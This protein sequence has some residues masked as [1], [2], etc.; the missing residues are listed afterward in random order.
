[1]KIKRSR[2][3]HALALSLATLPL[4]VWAANDFIIDDIRVEGLQ[5]ISIGTIF[6]YLP[7]KRG[8]QF[9]DKISIEAIQ[10]LYRT[11]FFKDVVL[12]REGDTLVVFVAERPAISS[13]TF[14]GNKSI[15]TDKLLENLKRIGFAEGRVFDRSMLDKVE[16]ELKR[17]Y[18]SMGKYGVQLK[19]TITPEER[20]RSA[21]HIAM[22]EGD[23]ATIYR[24]NIV[25]NKSFSTG[26]LLSQFQLGL[27]PAILPFSDRDKYSKQKLAGDLE[28]LRSWYL[29]RGYIN[30]KI[31]STQVS[32]TPDYEHIY[33]TINIVE[34]DRYTVR[35]VKVAGESLVPNEIL[36]ELINIQP[37]D[38]FSRKHIAESTT[39]ISDR[40]GNEG[41]AFAN[42]NAIPELDEENK[43]VSLT[44]FVDPG[45]RVYVRRVNVF[46]NTKTKD[47]VVRREIRQMEGGWISTERIK[48]SRM[49]LER[50]SYLESVNVETPAV[51]GEAEQVDVNYT[52]QE[53]DTFGSLSFG[54]GYGDADG[55]VFN[56]SVSQDNFL[57]TGQRFSVD[58]DTSKVSS[59]YSLNLVDPYY[60]MN[61][62]SR[63]LNFFYRSMDSGEASI[64]E[65]WTDS[66][67]AGVTFGI[68]LA[69][70]T[71]AY[72]GGSYDHTYLKNVP[73][74]TQLIQDFVT[75]N[76]D[77]SN[78]YKLELS[79]VHDTRNRY[80]FPS[81]G[82][83]I[84]LGAEI[85][86]PIGD[87]QFYKLNYRHKMYIP[88][89]ESVILS[90]GGELAYGHSY[91]KTKGVLPPFERYY[92]GGT[93]SVR[94]YKSSSLGSPVT[95]DVNGDP[96]GGNSK[97]VG[98]LE[99][100]LPGPF[101]ENSDS[102][103]L[104]IFL[105]GGNVYD[106]SKEKFNLGEL[107][108]STGAT[109]YWM[110]PVGALTFTIANA[111]N[112]KPGDRVES[113]QFNLGTLY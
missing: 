23:V 95:K 3:T 69:E 73:Q 66:Y 59:L 101:G 31:D 46:G 53:R 84:V 68:P 57:G 4:S 111:L 2:L 75:D 26:E 99:L 41:Y 9:D 67:G 24:I 32:I 11:G 72:V 89:S 112:S 70:F 44:F 19:T 76:G 13:I 74:S 98:N 1:M 62:I 107:R 50:L 7:L 37:G 48:R 49:R 40:L 34:G 35:D 94:G 56:A 78:A 88:F 16:Q 109:L 108:Y 63:N 93:S 96:M 52:I 110:T 92:S 60:T 43:E 29:D 61:G 82:Q 27:K 45:K 47:E 33:V 6:S 97:V 79:W 103:R 102:I 12:E 30:F 86:T 38:I 58:L 28:T 83:Q 64:A 71:T 10:A 65:Y 18:L 39:N 77:T 54:V 25:G 90:A 55:V 5:R 42:I 51:P 85:A 105:D 106:L 17:Q 104:G 113:F 100:I 91:G 15:P 22:A 80:L 8:D 21:I 87:L 14:E 20:N 36:R 81:S